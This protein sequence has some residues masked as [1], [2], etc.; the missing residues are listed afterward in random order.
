MLGRLRSA[1]PRTGSRERSSAAGAEHR[2]SRSRCD[3]RSDQRDRPGADPRLTAASAKG[4]STRSTAS[5][6]RWQPRD[7]GKTLL[8]RHGLDHRC[9]KAETGVL[10]CAPS[11]TCAPGLRHHQAACP[12]S[13]AAI[14]RRSPVSSRKSY[15]SG[16]ADRG[17]R[18]CQPWGVA[19]ETARLKSCI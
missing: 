18:R 16:A 7:S 13:A 10:P 3:S 8:S 6:T 15:G 4:G 17:K 9:N 1:P 2:H 12:S 5:R 14:W 11:V 19:A